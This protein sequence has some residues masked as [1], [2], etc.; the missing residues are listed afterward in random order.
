MRLGRREIFAL[1]E[2]AVFTVAWMM[3]IIAA[4]DDYQGA[5]LQAFVNLL[6][7]RGYRLVTCNASGANAFFVRETELRD[8]ELQP[9]DR[10]YQPPRFHLIE[11]KRGHPPSYRHLAER[12]RS[13]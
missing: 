6:V 5:S 7:P 1:G 2:L 3:A 10:L 8:I 11:W 13:L 9:V 4:L 12:L